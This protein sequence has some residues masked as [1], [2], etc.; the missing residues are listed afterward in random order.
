MTTSRMATASCALGMLT[1]T[2]LMSLLSAPD[3]AAEPA[4]PSPRQLIAITGIVR[5]FREPD[6]ELGHREFECLGEDRKPL[7]GGIQSAE[8]FSHWYREVPGVNRS[9]QLTLNLARQ[10]DGTY[11][12][13]DRLHPGYKAPGGFL[14]IEN[15]LDGTTGV[16][17]DRNFHFVTFELHA[18]FT[19][20]SGAGQNFE[21]VG[22]DDVWVFING[23]LV[24]DH[25]G[26]HTAKAK[27][28]TQFVDLSRLGLTDGETYP[29]DFFLARRHRVQ[30]NTRIVTNLELQDAVPMTVR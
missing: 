7:A 13:D 16:S 10:P 6:H 8:S 3:V 21:F 30:S 12:F 2:G 17:S 20:R 5:D 1:Y 22:N 11:V 27:A 15:R 14:P 9:T 29:L 18:R 25:C 19:Y 24:I 26:V 4:H 23:R 28:K